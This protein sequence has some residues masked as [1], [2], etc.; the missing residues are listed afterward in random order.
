VQRMATT[1]PVPL[2][3][4]HAMSRAAATV[5][6]GRRED[7]VTQR[8]STVSRTGKGL[9]SV[10]LIALH[11][12]ARTRR[13]RLG[14]RRRKPQVLIRWGQVLGKRRCRRE[15]ACMGGW[16]PTC[17]NAA[18]RG[19]R[20]RQDAPPRVGVLAC[21]RRVARGIA[22]GLRAEIPLSL[23]GTG[24]MCQ[25]YGRVRL[26][27]TI[28]HPPARQRAGRLL[29]C[30]CCALRAACCVLRAACCMW[31]ECRPSS[32]RQGKARRL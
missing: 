21:A 16:K 5:I 7:A 18:N 19:P 29:A 17:P 10:V 25:Y 9:H 12:A 31:V 28:C 6:W 20:R 26:D 30:S 4:E 24:P 13:N 27:D 32:A 23:C 14:R 15:M 1:V 2:H 8:R 22:R 11:F 3:N